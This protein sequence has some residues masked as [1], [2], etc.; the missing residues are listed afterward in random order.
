M[1][2]T[3]SAMLDVMRDD[4]VRTARSKGLAA[5]VVVWKHALPNA[6]IP[7]VSLTSTSFALLLGGVVIIE[8]IFSIPG[9]GQLT[10]TSVASRDYPQIMTNVLLL[11]LGIVLVNF[12]NDLLYSRLDPR[13]RFS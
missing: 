1:R 12:V 11:S 2:M 4:F 9:L 7:V 13:I 3:R 8:T 5:G 10:V 6:L